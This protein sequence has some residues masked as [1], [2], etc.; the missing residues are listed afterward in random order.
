MMQNIDTSFVS[1]LGKPVTVKR[2]LKV[3][4]LVGT[5]LI[6]IN[7]GDLLL[8]GQLP[9]FW[10]IILTY[11]VPYSVSSY[12]TAALLSDINRYPE[13]FSELPE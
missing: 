7:Q 10:K 6:L 3:S 13:Q 11:I 1:L 12:S 4:T 9:Q 8:S 5:I 2:A